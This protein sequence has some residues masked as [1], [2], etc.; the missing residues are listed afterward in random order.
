MSDYDFE[1]EI[2]NPVLIR[3]Y[4]VTESGQIVQYPEFNVND[5]TSWIII[6]G[7]AEPLD[8]VNIR[9]NAPDLSG[10]F[11]TFLDPSEVGAP[12]PH[13]R[14]YLVDDYYHEL[15]NPDCRATVTQ[16]YS[17]TGDGPTQFVPEDAYGTIQTDSD[18]LTCDPVLQYNVQLVARR[19]NSETREVDY[20]D[21]IY[22]NFVTF[23]VHTNIVTIPDP[24]E[25]TPFQLLAP[26]YQER[27]RRAVE[28]VL[29][30]TDGT[31]IREFAIQSDFLN[32]ALETM[33]LT[34][35]IE[36]LT[37]VAIVGR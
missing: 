1:I 23:T 21:Y 5:D 12:I 18:P 27:V 15:E 32:Y 33:S 37:H 6:P 13:V 26:F 17:S 31:T 22:S 11:F 10:S 7:R 2:T 20:S 25:D 24:I 30:E 36:I 29:Q 19:Y 28:L 9:F 3:N 8:M 34:E 4:V 14:E 35:L 16:G